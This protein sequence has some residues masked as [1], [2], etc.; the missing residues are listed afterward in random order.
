[1]EKKRVRN[2]IKNNNGEARKELLEEIKEKLDRQIKKDGSNVRDY[3][4]T[5]MARELAEIVRENYR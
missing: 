5:D 1:M 3:D 2:K 4:Y